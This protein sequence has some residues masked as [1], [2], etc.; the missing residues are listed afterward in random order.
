MK[1]PELLAPAGSFESVYTAL[2]HGADAVYVG[3]GPYN[4]R[5]RGANFSVEEFGDCVSYCKKR[6]RKIYAAVNIM[7]DDATLNAI[8]SIIESCK[9]IKARPDAFIVSDPGV[10]TVCKQSYKNVPL[11]LSTQSGAFNGLSASFWRRNGISRIVLPREMTVERIASLVK[12]TGLETEIFIHG[13]M[14]VSISGRC[15][16]GAYL[17]RRHPN[18]GDCPQPC[19]LRYRIAPQEKAEDT[20]G[21]LT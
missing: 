11:H 4:L 5:A 7:P 20:P 18:W 13:A 8:R 2:D 10:V 14:C 3:L 19:R 6:K 17:G 9:R 16:L 1:A 21:W 12:N 15:L